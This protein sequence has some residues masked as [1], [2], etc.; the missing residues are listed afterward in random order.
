M[1]VNEKMMTA[2]L[3]KSAKA[4]NFDL[5]KSLRNSISRDWMRLADFLSSEYGWS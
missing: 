4:V 3:E 1:T 5:L 2:F